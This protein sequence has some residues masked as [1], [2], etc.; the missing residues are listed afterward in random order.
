MTLTD[1]LRG[2]H[3]KSLIDDGGT[4]LVIIEPLAFVPVHRAPARKG[5]SLSP[6]GA[7]A[8]SRVRA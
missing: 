4:P 5:A 2:P 6:G 7:A 3:I 1:I 8:S